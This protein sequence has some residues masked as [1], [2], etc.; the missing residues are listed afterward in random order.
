MSGVITGGPPTREVRTQLMHP[1]READP[2]ESVYSRASTSR[3][4]TAPSSSQTLRLPTD[5]LVRVAAAE[6]RSGSATPLA[7]MAFQPGETLSAAL[8][9]DLERPR[10]RLLHD[11]SLPLQGRLVRGSWE[12]T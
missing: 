9:W 1:D 4:T 8:W 10:P 7:L 6:Q 3:H 11:V 2:R 12:V 5:A